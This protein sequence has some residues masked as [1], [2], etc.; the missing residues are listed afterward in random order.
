M[1]LEVVGKYSCLCLVL[2]LQLVW[3]M[4]GAF[5]DIVH[6][7]ICIQDFNPWIIMWTI[8]INHK[9]CRS[10]YWMIGT[11]TRSHDNNFCIQWYP[12][13]SVN[14]ACPIGSS[15]RCGSMIW[16]WGVWVKNMVC[17]FEYHPL[18]ADKLINY[19]EGATQLE[20]RKSETC[21]APPL[22]TGKTCCAPL[23][24]CGNLSRPP[25]VWLI[26]QAPMKL[27]HHFLWPPFSKAK[28]VSTLPLFGGLNLHLTPSPSHFVAPLSP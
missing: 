3:C 15:S 8:I 17:P 7:D 18:G 16:V 26:P 27:L 4:L 28:T 14:C 22:K 5:V 9:M 21:C 10:V 24:K 23:S 20:N 25:S 6:I 11:Q 1:I 19:G 2:Q 12:D 13:Y